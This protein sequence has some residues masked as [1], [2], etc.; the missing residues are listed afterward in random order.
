M[1][2]ASIETVPAAADNKD[3]RSHIV[4]HACYP[5]SP[6]ELGTPSLC[7]ERVLGIRPTGPLCETCVQE[8]P[9]HIFRH[10]YGWG[11]RG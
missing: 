3:K 7:G 4:C 10:R 6:P 2:Q 5:P 11:Q 1:T 8:K 9:R